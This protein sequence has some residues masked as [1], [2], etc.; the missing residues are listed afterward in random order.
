MA[1]GQITVE[2]TQLD[3]VAEKV[4]GYADS[5]LREYTS[6]YSLV[7]DMQSAWAGVDNTAYTAQIEGFKDDFQ[8][9]EK[10]MRDYA[11]FLKQ[12][13][14]KYRAAQADIKTQAQQLATNA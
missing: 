6:L 8:K 9:M 3:S 2:T 10:L 7:T 14:A 5:Y 13:A 12:T 4:E 11:A 1:R